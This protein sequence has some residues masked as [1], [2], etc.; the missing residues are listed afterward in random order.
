MITVE[1]IAAKKSFKLKKFYGF[2]L[3]FPVS[4]T[5]RCGKPYKFK[6][7]VFI[8]YSKGNKRSWYKNGG[9]VKGF[10]EYVARH[11]ANDCN[12]MTIAEEQLLLELY[13]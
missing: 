9:H 12:L 6:A 7:N 3:W 5:E 10:L 1:D 13:D 4:I 2:E 8:V 11:R